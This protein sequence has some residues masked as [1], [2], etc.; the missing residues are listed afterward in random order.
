MLFLFSMDERIDIVTLN[1]EPTG[2]SCMKSF[3]HEHGLLHASV[4]I[5]FYT[6]SGDILIQKRS[7][8]K[9][10]YPNLWDISVAGHIA[11]KETAIHSAVREIKE[12]IGLS[13]AKESLS[14]KGIWTEKHSHANGM[15]DH[16]VHHIYITELSLSLESL[17]PQKEEVSELKLISIHQLEKSINQKKEFV[18][19]DPN[20]YMYIINLLRE[21][22]SYEK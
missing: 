19:H 6:K 22:I 1:G 18:P 7:K 17:I 5:W 12:E 15:V 14:Y 11:S 4:H 8:N 21:Q 16:E 9:D 3:A 10:I 13:I 20:Y 2:D